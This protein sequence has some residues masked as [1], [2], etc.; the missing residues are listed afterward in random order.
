[1]EIAL[2]QLVGDY[3]SPSPRMGSS[4]RDFTVFAEQ[5][6][7]KISYINNSDPLRN[8]S[9]QIAVIVIVERLY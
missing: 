5:R 4:L 3:V 9:L 6:G 8:H 2:R 1:I 7:E